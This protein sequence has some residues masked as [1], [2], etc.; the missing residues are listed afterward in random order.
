MEPKDLEP[1]SHNKKQKK[2]VSKKVKIWIVIAMASILVGSVVGYLLYQRYQSEEALKPKCDNP[3]VKGNISYKTSV[4]IYHLP[5]ERLYDKTI[6]DTSAGERMFCT[7][8]DAKD[9]G[10]R[11][12][13]E[14]Q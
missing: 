8:Q 6:I 7:E 10:W 1:K 11:H 14:Q 3:I 5:G 13:E 4:K 9:A 12:T 2:I